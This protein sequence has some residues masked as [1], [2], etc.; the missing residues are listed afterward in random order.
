M[1]TDLAVTDDELQGWISEIKQWADTGSHV[2]DYV[3][4]ILFVKE[5]KKLYFLF[6]TDCSVM[7]DFS[8]YT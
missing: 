6:F 8:V 2:L 3:I 7:Y 1:K 4:I 5:K